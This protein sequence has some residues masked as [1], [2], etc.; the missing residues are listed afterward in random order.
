MFPRALSNQHATDVAVGTTNK[1]VVQPNRSVEF[2]V[3]L[4]I[5]RP[6]VA[7]Q[8]TVEIELLLRKKS[9]K[10]STL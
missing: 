1:L 2:V 6:F 9:N 3:N 10:C 8:T 5:F 7:R 4:D